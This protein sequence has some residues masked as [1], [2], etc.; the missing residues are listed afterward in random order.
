MPHSIP[1]PVLHSIHDTC[2]LLLPSFSSSSSSPDLICQLL[3]QWAL[4]DLICQLLIAV[5]LAG[6]HLPALD[7]SGPCRTSTASSR[8]QWA[9]PDLNR[10]DSEHCGP[11][12]TST[13][14]EQPE[15]KPYR[16]PKRMSEDMP[17]RMPEDMPDRKSEDM[18][19]RMSDKMSEDMPDR[20][21]EDM[22]DRS[23]NRMP[24][25]M[26]EDLPDRMLDGMNWMPWWGSIEAAW[27]IF[28]PEIHHLVNL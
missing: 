16:M 18:P 25:R 6:R 5:G 13:G 11:C 10:R 20:M 26:P 22:P 2:K 15:T 21:P 27:F 3:I 24:N 9:S 19:D 23:S 17:N 4:P 8:S 1:T 12:R 28:Q 7:R 14:K